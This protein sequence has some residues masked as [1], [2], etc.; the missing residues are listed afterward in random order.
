MSWHVVLWCARVC[1]CCS[2]GAR[3]R[4]RSKRTMRVILCN[5]IRG[6]DR[7]I[8]RAGPA[9]FTMALVSGTPAVSSMSVVS[10][11]P[12]VFASTAHRFQRLD[13]RELRQGGSTR[14][15]YDSTV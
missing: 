2:A 3:A 10:G 7:K 11:T 15:S 5:L 8:A 13:T 14:V 4:A 9:N 6:D 1:M 12:F